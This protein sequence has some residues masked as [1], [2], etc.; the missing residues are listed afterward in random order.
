MTWSGIGPGLM[1]AV[2]MGGLTLNEERA[3][4]AVL[5]MMTMKKRS[6]FESID[7]VSLSVCA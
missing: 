2:T 5:M 3:V 1:D 6:S 4:S 7:L